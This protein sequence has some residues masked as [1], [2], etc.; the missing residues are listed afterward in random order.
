MPKVGAVGGL[1]ILGVEIIN[2]ARR[3]GYEEGP[4]EGADDVGKA[5]LG[6]LKVT[7]T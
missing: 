2:H 5:P 1:W 3:A 4:S 6:P 7:L